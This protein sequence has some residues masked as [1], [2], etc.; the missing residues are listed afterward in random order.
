MNRLRSLAASS[1]P[2][3]TLQFR[4]PCQLSRVDPARRRSP[5]PAKAQVEEEPV[6]RDMALLASVDDGPGGPTVG[7]NKPQRSIRRPGV[8]SLFVLEHNR[9]G[10]QRM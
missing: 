4:N 9:D 7:K 3:P 2:R 5:V 6:G 1:S 10:M 8:V